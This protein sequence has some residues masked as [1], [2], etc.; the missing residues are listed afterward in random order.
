MNSP[1]KPAPDDKGVLVMHDKVLE[2]LVHAARSVE[3]ARE[4]QRQT[5]ARDLHDRVIQPL[6][7][8][9]TAIDVLPQ[10][11][12]GVDSLPDWMLTP[13]ELAREALALCAMLSPGCPRIRTR[14]RDCPTHFACILPRS[15][16]ITA[17]A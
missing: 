14:C 8:L 6:V 17:C 4:Q 9:V 16:N 5:L 11:L 10:R 12:P 7:A 15:S 2:D 3:E 1:K 13:K